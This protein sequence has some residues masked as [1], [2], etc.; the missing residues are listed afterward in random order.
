MTCSFYFISRIAVIA[1]SANSDGTVGAMQN[2][3]AHRAQLGAVSSGPGCDE[4]RLLLCELTDLGPWVPVQ[5]T[6]SIVNLLG[7]N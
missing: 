7:T 3:V 1:F 6:E 5:V 4:C 2:E